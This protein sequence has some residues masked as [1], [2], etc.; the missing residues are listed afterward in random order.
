MVR[1]YADTGTGA[2][3]DLAVFQADLAS[4][5][6]NH[7]MIGQVAVR[8]H[9]VSV[10]SSSVILVSQLSPAA[11]LASPTSFT[12]IWA[13]HGSVGWQNVTFWRV[14]CPTDFVALGDVVIAN[15]SPP[16]TAFRLKYACIRK[17]LLNRGV[18]NSTPIWTD[19]G[20]GAITDGS[21]W[22]V[23]NAA[24]GSSNAA[25]LAGFFKVQPN[26]NKPN[27]PVYV[28]PVGSVSSFIVLNY[29]LIS[30]LA[31]CTLVF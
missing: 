3:W 28:L 12:K 20:S 8:S 26:Y 2:N 25:G 23:Q 30:I 18:I 6:S 15:Y 16:S 1:V 17:S 14:N 10:P 19:S 4:I 13:D 21:V 11:D 27:Y 31:F 29:F 24:G 22:E 5:P 9:A 7:F